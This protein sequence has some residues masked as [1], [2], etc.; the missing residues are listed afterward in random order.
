MGN[1]LIKVN[2]EGKIA[3]V[4]GGAKG[5]G[6]A[7]STALAANGAGI[8]VNYLSSQREAN[9]LVEQFRANG[10]K[11]VAVKADIAVPEETERLV[12]ETEETMGGHI[13]ILVNNAGTQVALSSIENMSLSLWAKALAINLTGAMICSKCVIPSMKQK[14]W[15][16]IINISSISARS[17]GGPGGAHYASAKGGL[18][19]FTKGLAKEL[20]TTGI[21]VNAIAPGVILTEMHEKF[22]TKESLE[23]LK[24][25][26]PLGRLGQPE[27]ITG[28]VLFLVSD[29][30]SYITGETIA[31]NGGLRMD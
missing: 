4:T 2:L 25:Q 20:G 24:R 30:A 27:D 14:G 1:G 19:A 26:I 12:R 29:S 13:D 18:S 15:G 6:K 7:I 10:I 16:R 3:L 17:G 11:A 9:E 23:L 22:S 28:A 21:T 8:S 5:I 31:V